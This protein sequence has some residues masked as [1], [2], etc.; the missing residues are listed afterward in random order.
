[1]TDI[2]RAG[3]VMKGDY[4]SASTYET[5]DAVSYQNG[6]YIA[7][8]NVPAGTVPTNTT[9]WQK[10]VSESTM[11]GDFFISTIANEIKTIENESDIISGTLPQNYLKACYTVTGYSD[12]FPGTITILTTGT[13]AILVKT[14]ATNS[15]IRIHWI[16]SLN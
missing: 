1:M 4:N 14:D 6:L 16:M 11:S 13:P 8:Q 12:N 7:K 9:Y 5:L 3:I 2:G 10:A 15:Q